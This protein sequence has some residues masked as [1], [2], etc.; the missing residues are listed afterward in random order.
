MAIIYGGLGQYAESLKLSE[1]MMERMRTVLGLDHNITLNSMGVLADS[2]A[3]LGRHEESL[4]LRKERATRL[5]TTHG[6]DHA[7]SLNAVAHLI[8][9]YN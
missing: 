6:P 7:D 9:G 2:Y 4:K 1:Q 3:H 8:D 5:R